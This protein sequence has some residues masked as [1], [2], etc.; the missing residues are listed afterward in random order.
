MAVVPLVAVAWA[1]RNLEEVERGAILRD[2]QALELDEAGHSLLTTWLD[3]E[4]EPR[5][6]EAWVQYTRALVPQLTPDARSQLLARTR[7]RAALIA[8]AAAGEP[9]GVGRRTS[10]EEHDVLRRIDAAFE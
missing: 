10:K 4:P 6:F 5:L 7:A 3:A 8:E 1:D 9:Y 2:P